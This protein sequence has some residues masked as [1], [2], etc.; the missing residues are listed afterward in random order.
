M[1]IGNRPD[2]GIAPGGL[3]LLQTNCPRTLLKNQIHSNPM[4]H[5]KNHLATSLIM[6]CGLALAALPGAFAKDQD[7]ESK[8]KSMDTDGDGRVSRAEHA[9]GATLMFNSMDA[10]HDGMVT[11]DEMDA[12]NSLKG[13]KVDRSA[14]TSAE[15][16]RMIDQN[17][18]GQLTAAEHTAGSAAMF[19]KMD[20]NGDGYLSE[21]E[22]A[23]GHEMKK[24]D[25]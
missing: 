9:A 20:T 1:A 6:T 4:K 11:A 7:A 16:I 14:K 18:D 24:K 3:T 10:N 19:D 8:F 22:L 23:A 12:A 17:G 25:K 15:K 5:S 2:G 21:S 13:K